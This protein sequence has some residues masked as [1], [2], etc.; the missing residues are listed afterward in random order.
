MAQKPGF[1]RVTS[2]LPADLVKNPVSLSESISFVIDDCSRSPTI[3][4]TLIFSNIMQIVLPPE[5]EARSAALS[6]PAANT[7]VR[8]T[9]SLQRLNYSNN[10]KTFIKEDCKK[11][12]ETHSL[13]ILHPNAVKSRTVQ[14]Q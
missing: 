14:P 7:T 12:N 4:S 13:D 2:L 6:S 10:S 11:S 5:V 1:F 8:S 3:E 9:L